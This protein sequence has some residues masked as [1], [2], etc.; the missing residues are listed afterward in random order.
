M[1]QSIP[2]PCIHS[3]PE[4]G[5]VPSD[6]GHTEPQPGSNL[7]SARRVSRAQRVQPG[8]E[9][10]GSKV[11]LSRRKD[12]GTVGDISSLIGADKCPTGGRE[13]QHGNHRHRGSAA[14]CPGQASRHPR[15]RL[16]VH[17]APG[18]IQAGCPRSPR[19]RPGWASME[20]QAPAGRPQR[21]RSWPGIHGALGL[22]WTPLPTPRQ[23]S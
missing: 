17:G 14:A 12:G 9:A 11:R 5:L 3:T 16:G 15:S 21:P 22:G 10:P 19:S 2:D 13:W 18:P 6:G 23:P 4:R 1:P 20:S 8:A 7:L